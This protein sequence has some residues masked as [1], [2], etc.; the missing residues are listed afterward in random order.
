M[1]FHRLRYHV[2]F[3]VNCVFDVVFIYHGFRHVITDG[4]TVEILELS[5]LVTAGSLIVLC[6]EDCF[7]RRDYY[8]MISERTESLMAS[9]PWIV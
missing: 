1:R 8:L 7:W 5:P 3:G 2:G 4:C 9:L 6:E